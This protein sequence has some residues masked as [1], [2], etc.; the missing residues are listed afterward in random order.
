M[1]RETE[2]LDKRLDRLEERIESNQ[3]QTTS[4]IK[5]LGGEIKASLKQEIANCRE[6]APLTCPVGK[7]RITI[8]QAAGLCTVIVGVFIALAKLG[9]L[10]GLV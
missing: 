5:A 2:L 3:K 6:I 10:T 4:D 8:A 7:N 1:T 9:L